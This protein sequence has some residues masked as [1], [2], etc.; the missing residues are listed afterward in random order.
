MPDARIVDTGRVVTAGGVTSGIDL[1]LYLVEREF[2]A[3]VADS[4]ATT[5]E[6][7]RRGDVLVDR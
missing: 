7:E 4:V 5:L 6:Y 2:G 1:A 3:E